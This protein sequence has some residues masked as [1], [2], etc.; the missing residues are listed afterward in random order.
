MFNT[1]FCMTFTSAVSPVRSNSFRYWYDTA[2]P[3]VCFEF[4][5]ISNCFGWKI[6]AAYGLIMCEEQDPFKKAKQA[7]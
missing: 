6:D 4:F 3:P 2:M 5:R 1:H 7:H